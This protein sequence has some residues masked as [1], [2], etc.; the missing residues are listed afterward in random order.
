MITSDTNNEVTEA[1]L[2]LAL[3]ALTWTLRDEVRAARL[4]ALTGLTPVQLRARIDDP[5]M[6]AAVLRFL[7]GHEPDLI[8]CAEAIDAAPEAMVAA[9]RRLEA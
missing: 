5:V 1:A 9:R 2:A 4:L 6:L 7:E 3:A 8:A